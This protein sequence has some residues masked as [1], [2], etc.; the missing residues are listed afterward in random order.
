[1]VAVST[2]TTMSLQHVE[3]LLLQYLMVYRSCRTAEE[4]EEVRELI[5]VC[6]EY[7][8]RVNAAA[9]KTEPPQ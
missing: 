4:R 3:D 9:A 6:Q 8:E 7:I 5:E 2:L 1:M